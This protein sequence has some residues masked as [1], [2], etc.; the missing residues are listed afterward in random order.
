MPLFFCF[1][2]IYCNNEIQHLVLTGVAFFLSSGIQGAKC[3]AEKWPTNLLVQY[4]HNNYELF[5][6]CRPNCLLN[7]SNVF[8][9]PHVCFRM[10]CHLFACFGVTISVVL[11]ILALTYLVT[12]PKHPVDPFCFHRWCSSLIVCLALM[13]LLH[14]SFLLSTYLFLNPLT[15]TANFRQHFNI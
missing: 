7:M 2:S 8:F 1:W 12:P 3:R 14:I 10:L 15:L 5:V 4:T 13:S 9:F 11:C 6:Q